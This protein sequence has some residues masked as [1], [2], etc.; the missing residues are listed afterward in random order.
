MLLYAIIL[1]V[2]LYLFSSLIILLVINNNLLNF[3][4]ILFFYLL[5]LFLFPLMQEY[6][7][8]Y[9]F[10]IGLLIL[11][12]EYDL[13]LLRSSGVFLYF[14]IFLLSSYYYYL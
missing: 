13:N 1:N 11:K 2:I 3:F 6:F 8:P 5:S 7:D 4:I 9:I 14:S 10:I 12:N